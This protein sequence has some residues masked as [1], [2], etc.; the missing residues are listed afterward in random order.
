MQEND[1]IERE[2]K[3][4]RSFYISTEWIKKS[5]TGLK[6]ILFLW[7]LFNVYLIARGYNIGDFLQGLF[8]S[9]AMI[10]SFERLEQFQYLV[11]NNQ[12]VITI[13]E[14]FIRYANAHE[15]TVLQ[16]EDIETVELKRGLLRKFIKIRFNKKLD[17]DRSL[18]A[19]YNKYLSFLKKNRNRKSCKW[20]ISGITV[21]PEKLALS[22][23]YHLQKYKKRQASYPRT[24]NT[25]RFLQDQK[26]N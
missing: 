20:F 3:M 8:V 14:K 16:F 13:E 1:S 7:V 26:K 17:D 18:I 15:F 10:A 19:D 2:A 9:I 23:R 11:K 21:E 24:W 6:V 5:K 22:I 25:P 12:P 4:P